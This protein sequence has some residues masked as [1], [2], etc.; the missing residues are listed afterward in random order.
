MAKS[1]WIAAKCMGFNTIFVPT[2]LD[3]F[4]GGSA[5]QGPKSI[6]LLVAPLMYI[7]PWLLLGV[8][9][10][11]KRICPEEV[12]A[13]VKG[14]VSADTLDVPL[15]VKLV[16]SDVK[17]MLLPALMHLMFVPSSSCSAPVA[18]KPV[19]LFCF[20]AKA[21]CVK[22]L[23]GFD[24]SEVLSTLPMP[25]AA[26]VKPVEF[27]FLFS[28]VHVAVETGLSRSA[29]LST[30][31]MPRP[32]FVKSVESSFL[33]NSV[34]VA[35]ETGLSISEVLST[36]PKPR[37]AFV[38]PV[39]FNFLF[40]SVHVAVDTGLLAS[41]VLSTKSKPKAVFEKLDVSIL[42]P[43]AVFKF[44]KVVK[45]STVPRKSLLGNLVS[46]SPRVYSN[47]AKSLHTSLS[48]VCCNLIFPLTVDTILCPLSKF[49]IASVPSA[50]LT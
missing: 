6:L 4:E 10:P 1:V 18:V 40:S 50:V 36:L 24:E 20:A 48:A 44:V 34:E 25:R 22:L 30:L 12:T 42:L 46:A 23:I 49:K 29:V 26:F 16:V 35:V 8:Q 27:N 19:K 15:I 31:P 39:E 38:K 47:T 13:P 3:T 21:V 7:C 5:P 45:T 28:S 32:V 43:I 14:G 9:S 11:V 33:C 41:E 2:D 37:A 17:V